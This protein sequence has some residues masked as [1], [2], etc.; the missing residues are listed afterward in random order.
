MYTMSCPRPAV[1]KRLA[2]ERKMLKAILAELL[3]AGYA[4]SVYNGGDGPEVSKAVDKAPLWDACGN[5]DL[6]ELVIWRKDA[7]TLRWKRYGWVQLVYG[8]DGWDLMSDYST[9]LEAVL[10]PVNLLSYHEGGTLY[11]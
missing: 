1:A 2:V 4:I 10:E 11:S 3:G 8:N 7:Q 6:D 5:A 9:N